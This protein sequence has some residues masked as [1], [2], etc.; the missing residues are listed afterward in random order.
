MST[1]KKIFPAADHARWDRISKRREKAARTERPL[2]PKQKALNDA[3]LEIL[4]PS[5]VDPK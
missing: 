5:K 4:A 2:T 3:F 1:E